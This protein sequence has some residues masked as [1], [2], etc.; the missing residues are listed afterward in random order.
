MNDPLK[1][2]ARAA[3]LDPESPQFRL[4]QKL[5]ENDAHLIERLVAIRQL[6]GL[7]QQDVAEAMRVPVS[8]VRNFE[9][10]GSDPRLSTIRRYAAAVGAGISTTVKIWP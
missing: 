8:T 10:I 3:G 6:M 7:S 5:A 4:R 1:E 9:D 2:L